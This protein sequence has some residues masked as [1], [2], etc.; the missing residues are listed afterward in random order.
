MGE[1]LEIISKSYLSPL[2]TNA[3][4]MN[5]DFCKISND[6]VC[7]KFGMHK[8]ESDIREKLNSKYYE[9]DLSIKPE[10]MFNY[11]QNG[12]YIG[13]N[14][15]IDIIK[16]EEEMIKSVYKSS[17]YKLV[18]EI[19]IK[20]WGINSCDVLITGGGGKVLFDCIKEN[21]YPQA[22]LSKDPVFDNF[23]GLKAAALSL[24]KKQ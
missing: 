21:Y 19:Q 9:Y 6:A 23:N 24:G 16:K 4:L 10:D 7:L 1:N 8:I 14:K 20:D 13:N 2:T 12:L 3:L 5:N 18:Q 17:L 15:N 11:L 22:V